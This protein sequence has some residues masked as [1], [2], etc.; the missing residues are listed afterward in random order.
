MKRV[1]QLV[2]VAVAL[3][4]SAHRLPAPIVEEASPSPTR[5]PAHSAEPK[6][7]RT[8][9][10]ANEVSAD[11]RK[12]TATPTPTPKR[13]LFD[14]TW[15]GYLKDNADYRTLVVSG[16]GSSVIEK[17]NY[18]TFNLKGVSDGVSLKWTNSGLGWGC[19]FTLV[20]NLDGKTAIHTASCTGMLGGTGNWSATFRRQQ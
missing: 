12:K 17:S 6:P 15:S 16:H 13:D 20:P 2:M 10:P 4:S 8:V 19:S 11:S 5:A 1:V 9:K 14:G 7:K 18:G 3:L